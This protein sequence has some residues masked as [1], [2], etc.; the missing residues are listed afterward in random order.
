MDGFGRLYWDGAAPAEKI[1]LVVVAPVLLL[2]PLVALVTA[3][4]LVVTM[5]VGR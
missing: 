2:F 4:V 1:R 3:A 5:L